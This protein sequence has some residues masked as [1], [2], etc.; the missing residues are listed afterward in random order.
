MG[1]LKP[2]VAEKREKD[3]QHARKATIQSYWRWIVHIQVSV[4]GSV[5]YFIL[6]TILPTEACSPGYYVLF[7]H[8]MYC[9]DRL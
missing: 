3:K 1:V 2:G 9:S 6:I 4:W 5:H 7:I 8:K